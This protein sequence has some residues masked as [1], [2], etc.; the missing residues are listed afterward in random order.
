MN[1]AAKDIT[2]YICVPI[3]DL[4]QPVHLHSLMGVSAMILW[5][6]KVLVILQR[7]IEDSDQIYVQSELSFHWVE[8][9]SCTFCCVTAQIYLNFLS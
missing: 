3:K 2:W 8:M 5:I 1:L 7:D 4:H 9:P 6:F